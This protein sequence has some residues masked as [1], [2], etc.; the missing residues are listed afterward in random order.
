[1]DK[2]G[3]RRPK[4]LANQ[5]LIGHLEY[6]CPYGLSLP[7]RKINIVQPC[8]SDGCWGSM[9]GF[10]IRVAQ[11]VPDPE[12]PRNE[13]RVSKNQSLALAGLLIAETHLL[14]LVF[15]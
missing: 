15:L 13:G 1:M 2:A 14:S 7:R 3:K 5:W 12:V 10:P 8:D 11:P 4:L 9:L 6:G